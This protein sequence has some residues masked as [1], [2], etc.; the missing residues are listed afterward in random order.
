LTLVEVRPDDMLELGAQP[1]SDKKIYY[2]YNDKPPKYQPMIFGAAF[3]P[4]PWLFAELI[5]RWLKREN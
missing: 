3:K 2:F 4:W 1:E 5:N